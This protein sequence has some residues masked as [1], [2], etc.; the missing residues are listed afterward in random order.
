[1]AN[2]TISYMQSGVMN[3]DIDVAGID[4][5]NDIHIVF[6]C[7]YD[8]ETGIVTHNKSGK[9]YCTVPED[10]RDA[11]LKAIKAVAI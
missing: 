2:K 3:K 4:I 8:T 11:V 5:N 6:Q 7:N 10:K 1:M 9:V